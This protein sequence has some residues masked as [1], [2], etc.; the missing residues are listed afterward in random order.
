MASHGRKHLR[1]AGPVVIRRRAALIF[2][3]L[4]QLLFLAW[5]VR[6]A[7]AEVDCTGLTYEQ[8]ETSQAIGAGVG[9]GAVL[10]LWFCT[11]LFLAV[12]VWLFRLARDTR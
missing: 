6:V 1:P 4:L 2:L 11:N 3:V 8:C 7:T 10:F 12:L 5:L 9:V